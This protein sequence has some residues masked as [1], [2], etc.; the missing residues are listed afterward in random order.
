[1]VPMNMVR[2]S[3]PDTGPQ[4]IPRPD[5]RFPPQRSTPRH[6]H[7]RRTALITQHF[8]WST[9]EHSREQAPHHGFSVRCDKKST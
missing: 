3:A 1:M 9:D 7:L 8:A 5:S 4:I 6:S 2:K